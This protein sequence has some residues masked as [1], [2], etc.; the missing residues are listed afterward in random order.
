MID[1][2]GRI[3]F[4]SS[5]DSGNS[6]DRNS[7]EATPLP[8]EDENT[9]PE[10]DSAKE[11]EPA[12]VEIDVSALGTLFFPDLAI[13][14]GLEIC[15]SLKTFELGNPSGAIDI[16]FL[17]APED[18]RENE[19]HHDN[20]ENSLA[21]KS[22]VFFDED[23]P[24]GFD[25]DGLGGF[26]LGG[27]VAFGEGGDA[28]AREA[29]LE[30]Q[31]GVF[32]TGLAGT[33]GRDVAD[34]D[35][36]DCDHDDYV[37]TM[38]RAQKGADR[39]HEDILSYFDQA[40]RKNWSSA[41]HWKIRKV[42]DVNKPTGPVRTRK[43]KEPFQID[44]SSPLDGATTDLIFTQA[45]SN[46]YISL[47]KKDWKSKSKNLL[48]DDKHFNSKQLL[49]L[50]L[51]PKARMARKMGLRHDGFGGRTSDR[52]ERELQPGE[53]DEAFWAQQKA[54][55]DND[56]DGINDLPQGNYDAN[57]FDDGLPM[58][59][60]M[61][62]EDVDLEFVDARDHFS[63]GDDVGGPPGAGEDA[64]MTAAFTP[65][66]TMTNPFTGAFGTSLV[67]STRRI[68]PDYVQYARVAKRVDVRRLKEEIWKGMGLEKVDE[69]KACF[70]LNHFNVSCIYM[71]IRTFISFAYPVPPFHLIPHAFFSEPLTYTNCFNH[72]EPKKPPRHSNTNRRPNPLLHQ[73]HERFEVCLPETDDGRYIHLFLLHMPPAP[74]QRERSH[75]QQDR[76]P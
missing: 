63:P 54:P 41:E 58:P 35:L 17:K 53:M 16:P 45:S 56:K 39:M 20:Q 29:A 12:D 73:C 9:A 7:L 36:V 23:N 33:A 19:D 43:E 40:L 21:N 67:T 44:F 4:D 75:H 32:D 62:D 25:D 52:L 22:G 47:P 69:V 60:G 42:K 28:W 59:G 71:H 24:M 13:L 55:L 26:D 18:W 68:R 51:K 57:F 5:D 31:M 74:C 2:Q 3:V 11:P 72:V 15:P 38:N 66:M 27:D 14:D 34:G 37:V 48:P 76:Q 6:S 49:S 50:F 8:E 10:E 70:F 64:G 65:G 1:S 61:D 30:A 46:S